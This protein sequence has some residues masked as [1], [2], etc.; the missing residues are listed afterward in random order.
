MRDDLTGS[1][2]Q[3][4]APLPLPLP[5]RIQELLFEA[6][7]LGRCDVIPALLHAGAAINAC[8][9]KGHTPLILASYH[10]H[11]N[12]TTLLLDH[13][14]CVDQGGG[15]RGDTALMGVAFKGYDQIAD[16]LL[17]HGANPNAINKA[18]QT[19]LMMAAL[20][21]HASIVHLLREYGAHIAAVDIAGNTALL[22]AQQQ[23]SAETVACL[24]EKNLKT[25]PPVS[26]DP[27]KT[28]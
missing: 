4:D 13:G 26:I 16:I 25:S 28:F 15:A 7:R 19:A 11:F 8:D 2:R 5:E 3:A 20:F 27:L 14:A 12:A 9:A 22:L 17:A 21:G 23:G 1:I 6:A 18:G 10:G 24:L